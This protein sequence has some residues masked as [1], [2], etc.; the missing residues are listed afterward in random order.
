[1]PDAEPEPVTPGPEP[2]APGPDSVAPGPDSVGPGPQAWAEHLLTECELPPLPLPLTTHWPDPT[3]ATGAQRWAASGAMA[4]TGASDGAPLLPPVDLATA[5][6]GAA[7]AFSVLVDLVSGFD[8]G[9]RSN[10]ETK[11]GPSLDGAGLLG[12]RAAILGLTRRG[13]VTAGGSTRLLPAADGWVAIGLRRPDDVDLVPALIG[14][15]VADHRDPWPELAGWLLGCGAD[16][17]VAR[18][19][20]LGL[21][22]GTRIDDPSITEKPWQINYFN[23][24]GNEN[25][26]PARTQPAL[27]SSVNRLGNS[28]PG[29]NR[30]LVLDLSTLWAGPLA[31]SLLLTA[32]IDVIKVESPDRP[33]GSR[34]G[35]SRFHNLLNAGKL[36]VAARLDG[37]LVR[38]LVERADLVVTSARP[39][40]LEQLGLVPAPGRSWLTVTGYG[41]TG[42][43]RNWVAYGDDAAVAAGLWAGPPSAPVFCGDAV[44]DPLT[45]LHAAVAALAVLISSRHGGR[46]AHLDLSL[47]QVAAHLKARLPRVL[48]QPPTPGDRNPDALV[49]RPPRARPSRGVASRL[50]ADQEH[51]LVRG[52]RA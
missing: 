16:E 12:E 49:F 5:A 51:P 21:P 24:P 42:P 32:G 44:A 7:L 4:L 17:A 30:P 37:P 50:G 39:R 25:P 11:S 22:A 43:R 1:M 29:S 8:P 35:P 27:T 2:V 33:D 48:P 19:Q 47:H 46:A 13:A 3:P 6:D 41:W 15:A 9:P 45:G 38:D 20:L 52:E 34:G 28:W 14:R 40:A 26:V 18:A 31:T 36:S 10:P 23:K